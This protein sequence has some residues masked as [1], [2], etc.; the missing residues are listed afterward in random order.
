MLIIYLLTLGRQ[1]TECI[2]TS[3]ACDE[4]YVT[5]FVNWHYL[6]KATLVAQWWRIRLPV[7]DTRIRSLVSEDPACPAQLNLWATA[8]EPVLWSPW[9]ATTEPVCCNDR[10]PGTYSP[11]EKLLQWEAQALQLESSPH[12]LQPEKRLHSSEDPEQTKVK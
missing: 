10:S 12:S 1:S 11:Q 2:Q 6:H 3:L 5:S 9:A 8:T 4:S 7:Q